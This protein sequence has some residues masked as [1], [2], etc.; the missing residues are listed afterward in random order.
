MLRRLSAAFPPLCLVVAPLIAQPGDKDPKKWDVATADL[1]PTHAIEFET[2]EGTWVNV[3]VSPD[4]RTV[5]FDLLG[6]LYTMPIEGTGSGKATRITSGQA[7]DMQPRFSPDGRWIALQQGHHAG[8]DLRVRQ[9]PLRHHLR[10][11]PPRPDDR[12]GADRSRR[13][14]RLDRAARVAGRHDAR[15]HSAASARS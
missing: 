11:H 5:V 8:A 7:F 6:D 3:D 1:G 9:E 15:V 2:A 14:R 12:P 13:A 4:G 10:H